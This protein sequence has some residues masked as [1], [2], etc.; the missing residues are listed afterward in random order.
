MLH[1]V[2]RRLSDPAIKIGQLILRTWEGNDLHWKKN[3][4]RMRK[5]R[6]TK[7]LCFYLTKRHRN[8]NCTSLNSIRAVNAWASMW[9]IGIIGFLNFRQ[10]CLA[11]LSPTKRL[12]CNP[13]R[14]VTAIAS[15]SSPV[16]FACFIALSNTFSM[17][18]RWRSAAFGGF[19]PPNRRCW[20]NWDEIASP[21]IFPDPSTIAGKKFFIYNISF[22]EWS[23]LIFLP[24][25]VSSQ[26]VSIPRITGRWIE[27]LSCNSLTMDL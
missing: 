19:I 16:K 8:G 10:R 27:G 6:D 1:Q 18:I 26:D 20:I 11:N 9:W 2:R 7:N 23:S 12:N 13:G 15:R 21:R 4:E 14:L 22:N 24:I 3:I 5:C 17:S 25:P